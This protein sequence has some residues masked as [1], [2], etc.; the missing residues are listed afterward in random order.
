MYAIVQNRHGRK[1]SGNMSDNA[2]KIW[3]EGNGSRSDRTEQVWPKESE[4]MSEKS[5]KAIWDEKGIWIEP[6][7][8]EKQE[9]KGNLDTEEKGEKTE[10]AEKAEG[11]EK[12]ENDG[13]SGGEK[14]PK[15]VKFREHFAFFGP[16]TALYA[17]FYA[18]CMYK[19]GSGIT[20]PFFLAGSIFYFCSSMKRLGITLKKGSVFYMAVMM[21]LAI[22]TFCTDDGRIIALNKT[23][24]FLLMVS[25]LLNQFLRTE[26]WRL[27][28][29][30]SAILTLLFYSLGELPEV[31][32]DAAAYLK[33]HKGKGGRRAGYVFLG[34]LITAPI[35]LVVLALLSS[36]DAVFRLW[37]DRLF[38]VLKPGNLFGV[39]L[40]IALWYFGVYMVL[41]ALYKK[42]V[43]EEVKDRRN[44]EPLLAI[45]VTGMLS[46]LYLV[47][48]GIQIVYLF[49]GNMQLPEGYTYAKYARE[50]FFQLLA[51]GVINLI[52]VLVC[53]A[54]FRKNSLLK[55]I[56]TVMSLCTFIMIASSAL[57]MIIYIRY[58]YL[59][60]LRI[61][62]LW[63]LAT[64]FLLFAGVVVSIYREEFPLFRYGVTVVSVLYLALSFAH[65]DYWIAR[66]NVANAPQS[67]EQAQRCWQGDL[68]DAEW[69]VSEDD[70]FQASEPYQDYRYLAGLSA[71]AAPVLLPYMERLGYD[72]R[73]LNGIGG[74]SERKAGSERTAP[75]DYWDAVRRCSG[76]PAQGRGN[77][78]GFGYFYLESL[79]DYINDMS[80]RKFNA[81]RFIAVRMARNLGAK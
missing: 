17:L 35:F 16:A 48:S 71:D 12:T 72:F 4:N 2:E 14:S 53:M 33:E 42:T 49:L 57:R 81:S 24:I 65:P 44:G 20:F 5:E 46:L 51:V 54:F 68:Q 31:W 27:G 70:F 30:F 7:D 52:I 55:G 13:T 76:D 10:K 75:E 59:T 36:A 64:L 22:S 80:V 9:E 60:F 34:L 39:L 11:T 21:L 40:R 41:S 50:G 78:A 67:M 8:F 15:P 58:Y 77:P 69:E 45:T 25:F 73:V 61:M 56:L 74:A 38:S 47:F 79:Q 37:T 1:E 23:G 6:E 19:N 26:K 63:A 62:V 66:V 28:K 29:Y 43:R 32:L 3:S 18:F